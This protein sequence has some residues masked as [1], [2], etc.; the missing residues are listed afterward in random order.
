MNNFLDKPSIDLHL[1]KLNFITSETKVIKNIK[2]FFQ[3]NKISCNDI[4]EFITKNLAKFQYQKEDKYKQHGWNI[5][6]N[7]I[8][9][10]LTKL[11]DRT[12]S[13]VTSIAFQTIFFALGIYTFQ[14]L[15]AKLF[16]GFLYV[17]I[18]IAIKVSKSKQ[19]GG[20]DWRFEPSNSSFFT[21]VDDSNIS[22][23]LYNIIEFTKK[24]FK[25]FIDFI[26]PN[27][28]DDEKQV[29]FKRRRLAIL[30]ILVLLVC[31]ILF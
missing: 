3:S 10:I 13:I 9:D 30:S 19:N 23:K 29:V 31:I 25:T 26:L 22:K 4:K 24:S 14:S 16:C 7:T 28:T 11:W 17:G 15:F 8:I 6:P 12:L 20:T 18:C 21:K 1:N 2:S 5:I 27:D